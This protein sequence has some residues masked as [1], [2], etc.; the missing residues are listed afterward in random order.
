MSR[1]ISFAAHKLDKE[2]KKIAEDCVKAG[3]RLDEEDFYRCCPACFAFIPEITR[4][5]DDFV[6]CPSCNLNIRVVP[7]FT[8]GW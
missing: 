7:G 1:V 5:M 4:E 2:N 3:R 6:K 8:R